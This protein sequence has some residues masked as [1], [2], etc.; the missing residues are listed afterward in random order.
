LPDITSACSTLPLWKA[1][2]GATQKTGA[3]FFSQPHLEILLRDSSVRN[4]YVLNRVSGDH[5]EKH[6]DRFADKSSNPALLSSEK[7]VFLEGGTTQKGLG[8][9]EDIYDEVFIVDQQSW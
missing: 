1:T 5:R 8:L 7:L 6:T 3:R 4:I 9:S 2:L